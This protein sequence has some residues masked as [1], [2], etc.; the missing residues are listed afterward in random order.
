MQSWASNMRCCTET[1]LGYNN[2]TIFPKPFAHV[3]YEDH[4]MGGEWNSNSGYPVVRDQGGFPWFQGNHQN[5]N[6]ASKFISNG[7]YIGRYYA[8]NEVC[9]MSCFTFPPLLFSSF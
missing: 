8:P 2:P 5:M 7:E 6:F 9:Y 1:T 3:L 4:E